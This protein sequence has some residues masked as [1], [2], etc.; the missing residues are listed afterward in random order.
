MNA[1]PA[2]TK[3]WSG[4]TMKDEPTKQGNKKG[5]VTFAR[6]GAPNSRGDAALHQLQGQQLSRRAGFRGVWRSHQGHGHRREDL[7]PSTAKNPNQ[8]EI[9][10]SG[11][12]V[13]DQG[14]SEARLH[15]DRD[16]CEV[17][18][19][20][21]ATALSQT[22]ERDPFAVLGP[23]RADDGKAVVIR[24]RHPAARVHRGSTDRHGGL[25]PMRRLR[26]DGTLFEAKLPADRDSRLP[27]A[28]HVSTAVTSSTWT[29][30]IG[31]AAC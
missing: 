25:T 7:R 15:Q 18:S 5:Y 20:S 10:A 3:A 1:N 21:L 19:Q 29:I 4:A 27:P 9:T 23:H 17:T 16:D 22:V 12:R 30:R 2:V 26:G 31:T 14:I 28:A 24:A 13:P 11:Q 8:G 6:T